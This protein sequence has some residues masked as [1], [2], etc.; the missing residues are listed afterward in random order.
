VAMAHGTLQ[1]K[2]VTG[3]PRRQLDMSRMRWTAHSDRVLQ[4][5]AP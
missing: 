4:R 2:G 1:L 3:S 5:F